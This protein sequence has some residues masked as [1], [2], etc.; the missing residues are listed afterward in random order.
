MLI[1]FFVIRDVCV[2]CLKVVLI[3]VIFIVLILVANRV[4]LILQDFNILGD[5]LGEDL[6]R[7]FE[8]FG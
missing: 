3:V 7:L 2:P 4:E 5:H 6:K 8:D 1:Y